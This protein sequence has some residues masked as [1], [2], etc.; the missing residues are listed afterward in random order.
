MFQMLVDLADL[1]P[2]APSGAQGICETPLSGGPV[3]CFISVCLI[4]DLRVCR[5]LTHISDLGDGAAIYSFQVSRF[6]L[7]LLS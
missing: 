2:I 4:I 1:I 7:G 6:L 3:G 5:L